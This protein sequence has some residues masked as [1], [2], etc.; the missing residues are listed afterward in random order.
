MGDGGEPAAHVVDLI[1][2]ADRARGHGLDEAGEGPRAV[3]LAAHRRHEGGQRRVLAGRP[4]LGQ[5]F[6]VGLHG[7]GRA[8]L[9][10]LAHRLQADVRARRHAPLDQG[11][12]LC[13]GRCR[14]ERREG[15]SDVRGAGDAILG[16]TRERHDQEIVERRGQ[17]IANGVKGVEAAVANREEDRE[18]TGAGPELLSEEHLGEHRGEG[19]EVGAFVEGLPRDLLR[20]EVRIFSLE[21]GASRPCR[22]HAVITRD[23]EVSELHRPVPAEVDVRRRDVTMDDFERVTCV[24]LRA[25]DGLEPQRDLHG[26][27]GRQGQGQGPAVEAKTPQQAEQVDPLDPFHCKVGLPVLTRAGAEDRDDVLVMHRRMEP[28]LALEHGPSVRIGQEIGQESLDDQPFR[29][30]ARVHRAREVHLG[31]A[32]HGHARFED[33]GT[34][35]HE[36]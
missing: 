17:A 12:Q 8:E 13:G 26:H 23:A 10:A 30:D 20:G 2:P 29:L 24:V 5:R 34:K 3:L 21:H 7:Q 36:K 31:R 9:L 16:L 33:V 27:V 15:G 25:V 4:L 28:R 19:E 22:D 6:E 32:A 18:L 1:A 35:A 11:R 14:H